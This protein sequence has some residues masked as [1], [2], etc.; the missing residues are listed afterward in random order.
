MKKFY[1]FALS[2]LVAMSASAQAL[3]EVKAAIDKPVR[4]F[5]A[6]QK[7]DADLL[8]PA[9][10]PAKVACQVADV[11]GDYEVTYV[12]GLQGGENYMGEMTVTQGTVTN[13]VVFNFPFINNGSTLTWNLTGTLEPT[14]GKI[15]FSNTQ[16]SGYNG[17]SV[18]FR[19][20]TWA[21]ET[22]GSWSVVD[23]IVA[24]Y[25]GTAIV[26]DDDDEMGIQASTGGWGCL[27][28]GVT[29]DKIIDDPNADPNEGWTSLGNAKFVDP[30]VITAFTF[31]DGSDQW[32]KEY[33][34]ELQQNDADKN[35]Y[36]LVNPY[37]GNFPMISYN[38]STT[39]NGYIQFNVSD[40]SHVWFN[41]VEAGF[42]NSQ[43]GITKL[44]CYNTLGMYVAYTGKTAEEIVE[45]LGDQIIYT[46]LK[47][48]VI[49]LGSREQTTDGV[50][51]TVY[52][53]NFGTQTDTT[54]GFSWQSKDTA[55]NTVP[56]DMTGR[57][58]LPAGAGIGSI[59]ADADENAPVEYFNA[60]GQK[61]LNPTAG[62]LVIRRQG[63]KVE[64]ILVK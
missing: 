9:K 50:T 8:T 44:Y 45:I 49:N 35:V 26:F 39:K 59:A 29:M 27:F 5:T 63:N 36:R 53:A 47:D 37:K 6:V 56:A 32:D 33:E 12:N 34:V 16:S 14:T 38:Q 23:N 18:V 1:A 30:Y 43:L 2:A 7:A 51:K 31:N 11:V 46:T 20:W 21:T 42:A 22:T 10:A 48:G 15:T 57:I 55:G 54:G 24:T 17:F 25:N 52:D 58:T 4:Q 64:K 62:Q 13:T 19:H 40:P 28:Y 41:S 61:V 3:T 60:M